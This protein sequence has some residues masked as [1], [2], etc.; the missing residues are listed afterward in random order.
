MYDR[1]I[2]QSIGI[3]STT[4]PKDI[5]E[6]VHIRVPAADW[7]V[8]IKANEHFNV[9]GR[10]LFQVLQNHLAA[11]IKYSTAFNKRI[12]FSAGD[13]VAYWFGYLKLSGFDSKGHGWMNYPNASI[14][15]IT[16]GNL[17]LTFKAEALLNLYHSFS[18]GGYELSTDPKFYNGFAYTVAIEQ[19]FF[20]QKHLTLAFTALYADFYWQLWSL[21]ETFDRKIF[22]PQVTIGLIL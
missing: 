22:Y 11:G 9:D 13:D 1:K 14:G 8:L 3:L 18:N 17:L 15:Y 2:Q 10:I 4:T 6:E 7:H 16:N 21:F 20:K 19:P 5:T 12:Y